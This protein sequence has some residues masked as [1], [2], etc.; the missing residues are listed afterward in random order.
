MEN[1]IIPLMNVLQVGYILLILYS[2]FNKSKCSRQKMADLSLI[3]CVIAGFVLIIE[4]SCGFFFGAILWGLMLAMD[5]YSY[6][7]YSKG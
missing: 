5:V 2:I 4:L 1:F 3:S 6:N 7:A